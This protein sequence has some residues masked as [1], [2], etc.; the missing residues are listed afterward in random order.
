MAGLQQRLDL[1]FDSRL[2]YFSDGIDGSSGK[3]SKA[4]AYITMVYGKKCYFCGE[5]KGISSAHLVAAVKDCKFEGFGRQ[6]G[7]IDELD[8]KSPRNFIP[9]CGSK[10]VRGTCHDEFD[11]YNIA[12][13]FNPLKSKYVIHCLDRSFK[14]GVLHEKELDIP[15]DLP[16]Y[17]R[18]LAWRARKCASTNQFR[19]PVSDGQH[20][21]F[22]AACCFSEQSK[23]MRGSDDEEE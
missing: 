19:F 1:N 20:G 21:E 4:S 18:V 3:H 7:Y 15:G 10:G 22:L 17:R 2:S 11:N 12:L 23:S 14:D 13:F 6:N 16:P 9:L 5:T 8:V